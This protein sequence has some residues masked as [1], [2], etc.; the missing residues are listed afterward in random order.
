ME[1]IATLI[2]NPQGIARGS[3]PGARVIPFINK[4]D[5]EKNMLRGRI[6]AKS[7]LNFH[8]PRIERVILGQARFSEPV[9][10]VLQPLKQCT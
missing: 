3:P 2:T 6:L 7:I 10:E 1:A 5:L 4:M 9:L 8:H